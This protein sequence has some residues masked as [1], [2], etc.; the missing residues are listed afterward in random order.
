M[1]SVESLKMVITKKNLGKAL[2]EMSKMK[3][4]KDIEMHLEASG[5]KIE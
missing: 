2:K 3:K 1:E 5:V 4:L